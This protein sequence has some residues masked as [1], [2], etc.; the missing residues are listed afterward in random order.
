MIFILFIFGVYIHLFIG[1]INGGV[2]RRLIHEEFMD[3]KNLLTFEELENFQRILTNKCIYIYRIHTIFIDR[4]GF[5]ITLIFVI[6]YVKYLY[7]NILLEKISYN[8]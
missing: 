5:I 7:K 4:H 6:I 8:M 2:I 1:L 3:L